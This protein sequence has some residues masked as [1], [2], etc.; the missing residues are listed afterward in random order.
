MEN[1]RKFSQSLSIDIWIRFNWFL[2]HVDSLYHQ[3]RVISYGEPVS[4]CLSHRNV[5]IMS[6][7]LRMTFSLRIGATSFFVSRVRLAALNLDWVRITKLSA[8]TKE[9]WFI[10][11]PRRQLQTYQSERN[12]ATYSLDSLSLARNL[13][14]RW[15]FFRFRS[16]RATTAHS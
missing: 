5:F 6:R 11:S 8:T 12:V 4:H 7:T 15:K 9:L 2:I 13:V 14:R 10:K 3:T 1:Y 16:F